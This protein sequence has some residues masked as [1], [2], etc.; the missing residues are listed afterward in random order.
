MFFKDSLRF[1]QAWLGLALLW[2]VLSHVPLDF[3]V[4]K[5]LINTGYG[6]VDICF[7]ASG[8]GCFYS[9]SKDSDIGSFMKRRLKRLA[10]TYIVF[11]LVWLAYQGVLGNFNFQMAIG[12]L[13]A[14]QS[15]TGLGS[16]FNWYISA[17][18]LFYILAPY[19]VA[20]VKKTTT[21]RKIVFLLFLIACSFPFW[22]A[23]TY[24]ITITRLPVFYVGMVFADM[25]KKDKQLSA[26]HVV[27]LTVSF[28]LG[29]IFLGAAYFCF[30]KHL[31][32]H[33]LYWY[34][35]I[36]ITPPL[37]IALS[38]ILMQI[39]RIKVLKPVIS[40]FYLCGEYSFEIYLVHALLIPC[41]QAGIEVFGLSQFSYLIWLG[42]SILLFVGCF[43]LRRF[44]TL[45]N[46]LFYQNR[47][48]NS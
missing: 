2:I 11:I 23:D 30:P 46:R 45:I 24:I 33:G 44:T 14:L 5:Y 21:L 13:F 4:L 22:R 17:L 41:I 35:F 27:C 31:W 12:N 48:G 8:I 28:I 32:S 25:C 1:R 42:S 10:P 34:P 40:F 43:I 18:L 37:C 29:V 7:F 26:K 38:C 47:K 16:D 3:G 39:E 36:F 9:L 19:F 6:G 20:I 15:F